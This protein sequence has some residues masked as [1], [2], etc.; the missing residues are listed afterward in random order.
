MAELLVRG[1]SFTSAFKKLGPIRQFQ[2]TA[3]LGS[4]LQKC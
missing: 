1:L 2:L 4:Y 3:K